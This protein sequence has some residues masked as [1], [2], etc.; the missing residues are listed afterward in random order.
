MVEVLQA[1]L[2]SE[3]VGEFTTYLRTLTQKGKRRMVG[4]G[5]N[6]PITLKLYAELDSTTE[7]LTGS[8]LNSNAK[9]YFKTYSRYHIKNTSSSLAIG[10][11]SNASGYRRYFHI[12]LIPSTPIQEYTTL[13]IWMKYFNID[14]K[15]LMKGISYEFAP[16]FELLKSYYYLESYDD[17][18]K[19]LSFRQIPIDISL[20]DHIELYFTPVNWK[21][22]LIFKQANT[23]ISRKLLSLEENIKIDQILQVIQ[24]PI[25]Y[26]GKSKQDTTVYFSYTGIQSFLFD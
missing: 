25:L 11:K 22:N 2:Y 17:I 19:F 21:Y 14:I 5:L 20:I 4:I 23:E 24:H 13:M 18:A 10:N 3:S 9:N 12:K 1:Q 7:I 15:N 8:F 6:D 16:N 26:T